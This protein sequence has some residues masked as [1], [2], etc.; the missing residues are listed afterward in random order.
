MAGLVLAIFYVLTRRWVA[1]EK[2]KDRRIAYGV[3]I[4]FGAILC[5][6]LYPTTAPKPMDVNELGYGKF[7]LD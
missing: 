3:A 7:K 6:L 2:R 4:A 5:W 1:K